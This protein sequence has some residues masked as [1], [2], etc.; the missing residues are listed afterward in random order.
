[1]NELAV[2]K[3]V[4][5]FLS[6]KGWMVDMKPKSRGQHGC[7]IIAKHPV[8]KREILIEVKGDNKHK[9][10]AIHNAFNALLGQI[11]SRM[12]KNGND[13]NKYRIYAIAFPVQW[14]SIFKKKI[15]RMNF[16][17]NLLKLR[18]FLVTRNE[19]LEKNYKYFLKE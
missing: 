3:R 4:R 14:K 18:V 12:D 5:Q 15:Q 1:M 11:I 8:R 10:P 17:W 19:V 6:E 16:G 2:E 9:T 7:D 13:K